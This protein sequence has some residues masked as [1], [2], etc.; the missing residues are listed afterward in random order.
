MSLSVRVLVVVACT[1]LI[2]VKYAIGL[3][4][5]DGL[6][7][8]ISS[9][10][11]LNKAKVERLLELGHF[12]DIVDERNFT[13][14]HYAVANANDEQSLA[15]V[16]LLL[17]HF[18]KP[19]ERN[20]DGQTPLHLTLQIDDY[21]RRMQVMD[22]LILNGALIS[23][24][25]NKG[26]ALL[27]ILAGYNQI[28]GIEYVLSWWG[29]LL[30][31]DDIVRAKKMAAS[32]DYDFVVKA[33]EKFDVQKVVISKKR[34]LGSLMVAVIKNDMVAIRDL[35]TK[36]SLREAKDKAFGYR[37]LH[38]AINANRFAAARVLLEAGADANVPDK[39]GNTPLH[40]VERLQSSVRKKEFVQLLKDHG[41]DL[42]IRNSDGEA[43]LHIAVKKRDDE[44][45]KFLL[46]LGVSSMVKNNEG[47]TP[48]ALARDLDYGEIQA[49]FR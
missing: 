43:L 46:S 38:I 17:D 19:R 45:I 22:W 12:V 41:A 37:P 7:P 31:I 24:R 25:D 30:T 29:D 13:A 5:A 33:L 35:S 39:R 27:D 28:S 42:N 15:I 23:E 2:V 26:H 8:L 18:A 44:L 14:L 11:N 21:E 47:K 16:K 34:D 40:M 6:P 48:K 49:L 1:S 20:S 4:Y 36:V 32:F 10:V 3:K 9:T